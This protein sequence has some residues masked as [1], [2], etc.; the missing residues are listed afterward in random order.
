M[1]LSSAQKKFLKGL[2]HSLTPVIH[3]GKEGITD[4]LIASISKA[5][6][7]HE[8]IKVTLLENADLER[9]D[10]AEQVSNSTSS[11]LIQILGKKILLYKSNPKKKKIILPE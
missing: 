1:P 6:S 4:R 3:I 9:D 5:L 11:E 2:G 8:L 7:D 10:A